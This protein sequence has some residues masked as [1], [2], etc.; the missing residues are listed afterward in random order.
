MKRKYDPS[1]MTIEAADQI[2]EI[3]DDLRRENEGLKATHAQ[4]VEALQQII[5]GYSIETV[6]K[7]RAA[8]ALAA[9]ERGD[10]TGAP[11]VPVRFEVDTDGEATGGIQFFCSEQCREIAPNAE[12]NP[13]YQNGMQP[14]LDI[15]PETVCEN[16][17]K[18]V[19]P[20]AEI[21]RLRELAV[22]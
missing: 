17:G 6:A 12:W 4:L 3:I 2:R 9:G 11:D 8:L 1:G 18:L 10:A 14:L 13:V 20:P 21:A 16:C 19:T 22:R 5:D 7:A 15:E